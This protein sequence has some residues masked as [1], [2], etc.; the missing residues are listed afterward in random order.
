MNELIGRKFIEHLCAY[1]EKKLSKETGNLWLEEIKNIPHESLDYITCEIKKKESFPRNFPSTVWALYH[2]WL[3]S[4]SSKQAHNDCPDCGGSGWISHNR[5][6]HKCVSCNPE[7]LSVFVDIQGFT[8]MARVKTITKN[9]Q[10]EDWH[11]QF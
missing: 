6:A 8:G 4:N 7:P 2:A 11:D 9:K 1:F 5:K 10:T 3:R